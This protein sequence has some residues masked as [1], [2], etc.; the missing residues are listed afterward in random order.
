MLEKGSIDW[1]LAE[2]LA[3]GSLM[4]PF[5][6]YHTTFGRVDR[7]VFKDDASSIS[8]EEESRTLSETADALSK[9]IPDALLGCVMIPV[10]I[11][12]VMMISCDGR[13]SFRDT[14]SR[15]L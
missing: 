6:P 13:D 14:A 9:S 8:G 1:A 12:R 2:Q 11:C 15:V 7:E 4:L 5:S 10:D 3:M